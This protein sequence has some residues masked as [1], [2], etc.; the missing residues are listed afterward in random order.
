M[1]A[2]LSAGTQL[3]FYRI[4]RLIGRGGM[5]VVYRAEHVELGRKAA[6]KVLLPELSDN[7]A[8]RQRFIQESRSA[9]SIDNPYIIPIYEAGEADGVLYIA[10]RYVNGVTLRALLER[11]CPLPPSKALSIIAQVANALDAAH[12]YGLVHRDVK[13]GNI[14]IAPGEG[15]DGSDH[16]YLTDFGL[17]KRS[18]GGSAERLT[19]TGQFLGTVDYVAPEQISGKEVDAQTDVYALGCVMYECLTGEL[20]FQAD[21]EVALLYAH[22]TEPPPSVLDKN[23]ELP[24]SLDLVF[25]KALAKE[26]RA[27]Y[28]TCRELLTAAKAELVGVQ[29][30]LE[31]A[32]TS[33]VLAEY[34][35][36]RGADADPDAPGQ[37]RH[38]GAATLG[39]AR[40]VQAPDSAPRRRATARGRRRQ[41]L[42]VIVAVVLGLLGVGGVL[43]AIPPD[44][45]LSGGTAPPSTTLPEEAPNQPL[46]LKTFRDPGAPYSLGYPASW[47]VGSYRRGPRLSVL[48][49]VSHLERWA[50]QGNWGTMIQALEGDPS[51]VIGAI[52]YHDRPMFSPGCRDSGLPCALLNLSPPSFRFDPPDETRTRLG[53]RR[54]GTVLR[55]RAQP[56][57]RLHYQKYVFLPPGSSGSTLQLALFASDAALR[58]HPDLF[59]RMVASLR[60]TMVAPPTTNVP[61][62]SGRPP[63]TSRPTTS[64]TTTSGTTTTTTTTTTTPP[65][66]VAAAG[67]GD[68]VSKAGG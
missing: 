4:E 66:S 11:E 57:V 22:L 60:P 30:S 1:A 51:K 43:R 62:T 45:V 9:A 16:V 28:Q 17:T 68:R 14:L 27:R 49:P 23:P 41:R 50:A 6:L 64:G 37:P 39:G 12:G 38:S 44:A 10:M 25:M 36:P 48:S 35:L 54:Y 56:Q 5:S 18:A 32:D 24:I 15:V 21:D 7:H 59:D 8:F 2:E 46:K 65:T 42:A 40:P 52:V 63:P 29:M 3:G 55:A 20:P 19:A 34:N 26:P 47:S 61:S 31:E 13:P 33:T 53:G 67:S 58:E